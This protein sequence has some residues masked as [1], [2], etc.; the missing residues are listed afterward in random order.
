MLIIVLAA[1]SLNG[2]ADTADAEDSTAITPVDNQ[3]STDSSTDSSGETIWIAIV[4]TWN[5]VNRTIDKEF[6]TEVACWNYY[7]NGVG[8]GKF[9][10]QVLDHQDNPPT[11][12]FNF[13]PDHLEFPIRIYRGKDGQ[14]Q[15][16]LT[17]DIKGRYKDL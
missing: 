15:I 17:C 3:E 11:K 7:E 8:E 6:T 12:D 16:W 4:M 13:G 2:C 9:G 1:L 10:S 5:P 14:G